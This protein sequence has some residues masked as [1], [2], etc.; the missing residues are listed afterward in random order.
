M[1]SVHSM[2]FYDRNLSP[3]KR[4]IKR[5]WNI[6]I[7][8][9]QRLSLSSSTHMPP[10][11]DYWKHFLV[12]GFLAVCQIAGCDRPT[13]SLGSVPKKCA[14]KRISEEELYTWLSN[15]FSVQQQEQSQTYLIFVFFF[16]LADF[17]AWTFYTEKCVN[18]RQKITTVEQNLCVKWHILCEMWNVKNSSQS[19]FYTSTAID[20]IDKYEVW[21]QI[22]LLSTMSKSGVVIVRHKTRPMLPG[23]P[24]KKK[25]WKPMH[26]GMENI[27][28]KLLLPT[29]G[30]KN[31]KTLVLVFVAKDPFFLKNWVPIF[32]LRAWRYLKVSMRVWCC[33]VS[34]IWLIFP[35][36]SDHG[37]MV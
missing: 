31:L 26:I 32:K 10:K 11:A 23:W 35:W 34:M 8:P 36:I 25:K 37:V 19:I 21:S 13:V 7:L 33:W 14:K 17:T 1:N 2:T 15:A 9:F 16:R 20:A 30:V 4:Q 22:I 27:L 24:S 29:L 18:S 12:Q 6:Q 3:W 28:G 5:L